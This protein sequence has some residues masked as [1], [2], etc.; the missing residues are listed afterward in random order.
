M[1][2]PPEPLGQA[3][4][5]ERREL[6]FSVDP[7]PD[8][9]IEIDVISNSV[10]R[11]SVYAALGVPEIW[12][13]DGEHL[14]MLARTADGQYAPIERSI[15]LPL[16]TPEVVERFLAMEGKTDQTSIMRASCPTRASSR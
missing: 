6:D 13:H 12:R 2:D 10:R 8:L 4:A 3:V 7:P 14:R 16:L 5:G 15:A 11:Y 9:A 1:D